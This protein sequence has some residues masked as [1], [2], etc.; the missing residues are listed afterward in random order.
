MSLDKKK[1]IFDSK[2]YFDFSVYEFCLKRTLKKCFECGLNILN[3]QNY[4]FRLKGVSFKTIV[5]PNGYLESSENF[6]LAGI[7]IHVWTFALSSGN[8]CWLESSLYNH[9]QNNSLQEKIILINNIIKTIC[10]IK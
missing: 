5:D 10:I 2:I 3:V 8:C 6:Y 1:F 9:D 4:V 7:A